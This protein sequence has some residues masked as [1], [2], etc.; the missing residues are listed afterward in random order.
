MQNKGKL[1]AAEI[2]L[3]ILINLYFISLTFRLYLIKIYDRIKV[4]N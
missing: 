3:L 1:K 4:W 2:E